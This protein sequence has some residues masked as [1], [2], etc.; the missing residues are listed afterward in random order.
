MTALRP[1]LRLL[2]TDDVEHIVEQACRV[3]ETAGALVENLEAQKLLRDAGATEKDGRFRLEES[4]VRQAVA[5]APSRIA[6]YDRAGELAMDLGEDRV[7]FDPGSAAIHIFD[8]E[9]NRRREVTTD[10]LSLIHISEPTRLC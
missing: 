9:Q 7:H 1:T 2:A 4:M 6:V 3:L 8:V 5:S 10:D